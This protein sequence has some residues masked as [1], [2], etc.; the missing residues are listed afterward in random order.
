MRFQST[1]SRR[2]NYLKYMIALIVYIFQS[3]LSAQLLNNSI[4]EAFTDEPFFNI[5]N[6]RANKI[7]R[8][9]GHYSTKKI[10]DQIRPSSLIYVYEFDRLGRLTQKYETVN[11]NGGID[12][13]V[14]HYEY[15]ANGFLHIKRRTDK[16]G[17]YAYVY[18]YDESGRVVREEFRKDLNKSGSK[19]NFI[20][21]KAFLITF[22]TSSYDNYPLQE[23]RIYFNSYGKPF[24]EKFAYYN[25]DGYLIEENEKLKVTSGQKKTF[26]TYNEK[27]LLSSVEI[28]SSIMGNSTIKNK[29]EYD[30]HS[31]LISK[32]IYRNDEYTT[33]IQVVYNE[34]TGLISAILTRQVSTNFITILRMDEYE[35][36]D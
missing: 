1:T 8:I 21:D 22:E 12:T 34:K 28:Q 36:Y 26:Y 18:E 4:G 19:V 11:A 32:E 17:F 9:T 14:T 13:I 16:S 35:F 15:N 25:E 23:K 24:Q 20:E 29:F 6:V 10:N 5:E 31:N 30:S 3:P 27:G 33:E 2:I 7:K